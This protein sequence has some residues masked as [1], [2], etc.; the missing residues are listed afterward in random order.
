MF[1]VKQFG[2][3]TVVVPFDTDMFDEPWTL[4]H[5]YEKVAKQSPFKHQPNTDERDKLKQFVIINYN[6]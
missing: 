1:G 4:P 5:L 6:R 3:R 2:N